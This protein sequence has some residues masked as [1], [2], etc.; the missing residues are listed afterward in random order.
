M[1]ASAR[2]IFLRQMHLGLL[3]GASLLVPASRRSEWSDEWRTELWYVLRDCSSSTSLHPRSIRAATAF[4]MG[5][6]SDAIWLRKRAWQRQRPLA[7]LRGSAVLCLLFLFVMFF[8]VWGIACVSARVTA[9]EEISRVRV[10]ALPLSV[11]ATAASD[12]SVSA[13]A[14][15]VAA[16]KLEDPHHC[17]DGFSHYSLRRE[18]VSGKSLPKTDWTIAHASSGFFKVLHLSLRLTEGARIK[19]RKLPQVVLS[20]ETWIRDFGGDPRIVHTEL[21]VGSVD[22]II[23]GVASRGAGSLPGKAN[24]WLADSE[25]SLGTGE[26]QFVVGHL[27][28]PGYFRAGPR[29]ALSLFGIALAVLLMPCIVHSS[30]GG[31]YEGAP[32]PSLITGIRFWAFLMAK[33]TIL[34]AIDYFASVDIGCSLAQPSSQGSGLL[35]GVAAFVVCLWGL[36]WAL[37][38]QRRRCPVCLRRM[39]HPVEVGQPSRTFLAWKGTEMVCSEGHILLHIP[40]VPTSWFGTVRWVRL[41]GSWQFLF[42]RPG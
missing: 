5:A 40:E 2:E 22:A 30:I 9:T 38:D 13:R 12:C 1:T 20:E 26:A 33:I 8:S 11:K 34:L 35:Q 3:W 18:M 31:H 41:D 6:Y 17:F 28:S 23:A 7:R 25:S 27:T 29:W 21:R 15:D 39:S 10:Y 32:K 37:R 14:D 42:A 36:S 19:Q 16:G 24:A 4:C